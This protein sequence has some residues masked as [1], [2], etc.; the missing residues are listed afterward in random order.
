[1]ER[2]KRVILLYHSKATK[3]ITTAPLKGW[4]YIK[5]V[6]SCG[7]PRYVDRLTKKQQAALVMIDMLDEGQVVEGVGCWVNSYYYG[8]PTKRYVLDC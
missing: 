2:E 4:P 6:A 8:H 1:M 3:R 5:G 7:K